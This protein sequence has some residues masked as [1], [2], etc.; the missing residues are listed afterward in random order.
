MGT[1]QRHRRASGDPNESGDINHG[2]RFSSVRIDLHRTAACHNG[3]PSA[4]SILQTAPPAKARRFDDTCRDSDG[5][6]FLGTGRSLQGTCRRVAERVSVAQGPYRSAPAGRPPGRPDADRGGHQGRVRQTART[7]GRREG[8]AAGQDSGDR[9][10]APGADERHT[11][12]PPRRGGRA[13]ASRARNARAEG[14]CR[15]GKRRRHSRLFTR[16]FLWLCERARRIVLWQ[17][18][19]RKAGKEI[20]GIDD[21]REFDLWWLP[22]PITRSYFSVTD[23]GGQRLVLFRGEREGCWYRQPLSAA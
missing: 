21:R 3:H 5:R 20:C 14:P 10:E 16:R 18:N 4:A 8:Q 19:L 11:R 1:V 22:Q 2:I 9:Q 6:R 7:S 23:A 13:L 15:L 12:T 17:F